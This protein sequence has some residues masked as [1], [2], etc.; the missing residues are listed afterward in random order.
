[1]RIVVKI[2]LWRIGKVSTKIVRHTDLVLA[3]Y[4]R[5]VVDGSEYLKGVGMLREV[6]KRKPSR[7]A[8]SLSVDLCHV[9]HDSALRQ[10][11]DNDRQV[12]RNMS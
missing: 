12:M 5:V 10:N 9:A 6:D 1:M 11:K 7:L 2:I 8:D 4:F 3:E